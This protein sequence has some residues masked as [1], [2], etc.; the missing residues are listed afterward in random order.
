M[1]YHTALEEPDAGSR[2]VGP[3][4][5]SRGVG[6]EDRKYPGPE[7]NSAP[8]WYKGPQKDWRGLKDRREAGRS[9]IGDHVCNLPLPTYQT[10]KENEARLEID[11]Y[12]IFSKHLVFI[13]SSPY[14]L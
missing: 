7:E 11:I 3:E 14:C 9:L 2:G 5:G 1:L 12:F 10:I 6:P 4:A 8:A 13:L